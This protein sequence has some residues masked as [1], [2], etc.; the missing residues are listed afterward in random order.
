MLFQSPKNKA[1]LVDALTAA[2]IITQN[3]QRQA[4]IQSVE[5]GVATTVNTR[6]SSESLI[7]MNKRA[8]V[9]I[10]AQ[11]VQPQPARE[12]Y[13]SQDIAE[14]RK[15]SFDMDV[16]KRQ[17]EFDSFMK[18][19]T[20]QGMDF[21][22]TLDKPIGSEMD[23]LLAEATSRRELDMTPNNVKLTHS[24]S[25]THD[26]NSNTTAIMAKMNSLETKVNTIEDLLRTLIA[27][28]NK[29]DS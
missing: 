7:D 27:A 11:L 20:P 18:R 29:Q 2:G 24:T 25:S 21:S 1:A 4:I 17:E 12:P 16:Q 10:R 15:T 19:D 26:N 8:L 3:T 22:D 23:A 14:A 28:V 5:K 9:E 6:Q 13:T